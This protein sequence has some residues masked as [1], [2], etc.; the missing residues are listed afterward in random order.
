MLY[1]H[2]TKK[3]IKVDNEQIRK[4]NNFLFRI[5]RTQISKNNSSNPQKRAEKQQ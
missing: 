2:V 4:N 1:N 5:L 3:K